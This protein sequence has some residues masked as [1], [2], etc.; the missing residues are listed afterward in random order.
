MQSDNAGLLT[1]KEAQER[2]RVRPTT[3][4]RW[5]RDGKISYIKIGGEV[6]FKRSDIEDCIN[7]NRTRSGSH[8]LS[9]AGIE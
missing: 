2:L 4:W 3:M 6:R 1:N 9:E 5:R 7:Q 8:V